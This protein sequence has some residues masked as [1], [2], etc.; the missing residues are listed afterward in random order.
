[1]AFSPGGT[2]L[3][4]VGGRGT[5]SPLG[6]PHGE[7]KIWDVAT[8]REIGN[9]EDYPRQ[10]VSVAFSPDG[11]YFAAGGEERVV[12]VWESAT[13][14]ELP[15]LRG[16]DNTIMR[17]TFR[18]T[19]R[20]LA[21]CGTDWTARVWDLVPPPPPFRLAASAQDEHQPERGSDAPR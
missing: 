15:A 18:P 17:V 9:L 6:P 19:G 14:R 12:R 20:F 4:S 16:H 11:R 10:F 5:G 2:R 3:V 7:V 8:G 13:S 1:A 21:S